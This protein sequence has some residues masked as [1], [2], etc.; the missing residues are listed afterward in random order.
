MKTKI[1]IFIGTKQNNN[2]CGVCEFHEEDK[3]FTAYCQLF[4]RL[5]HWSNVYDNALRCRKCIN[6]ERR[7]WIDR[8]GLSS[9]WIKGDKKEA[10]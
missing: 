7:T 3:K 2:D 4:K 8:A 10:C 5:L 6:A 1:A 9:Y